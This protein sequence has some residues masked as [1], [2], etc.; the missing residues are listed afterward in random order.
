M[1]ETIVADADTDL[2]DD[3]LL[4]L[5]D[6]LLVEDFGDVDEDGVRLADFEADVLALD[7]DVL[8]LELVV[9][10]DVLDALL[11]ELDFELVL[12]AFAVGVAEPVPV[13]P[14]HVFEMACVPEALTVAVR[15]GSSCQITCNQ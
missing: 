7:E 12:V 3:V 8:A 14:T 10:F 11:D 15:L 1:T 2:D 6:A 5:E 4:A 9:D 13:A